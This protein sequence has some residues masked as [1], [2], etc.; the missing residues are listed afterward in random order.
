MAQGTVVVILPSIVRGTESQT[1][2]GCVLLVI[3]IFFFLKEEHSQMIPSYFLF[4]SPP[5]NS[6]WIHSHFHWLQHYLPEE[7]KI[8]AWNQPVLPT[9]IKKKKSYNTRTLKDE[10]ILFWMDSFRNIYTNMVHMVT[11]HPNVRSGFHGLSCSCLAL[12]SVTSLN[13]NMPL[14]LC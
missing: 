12:Y 13:L 3:F 5:E 7:T 9:S 11:I 6:G 1:G 8:N 2:K 10:S 14:T 4:S